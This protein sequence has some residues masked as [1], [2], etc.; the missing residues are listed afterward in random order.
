MR[1]FECIGA[2][3]RA[4][5]APL[6]A[7]DWPA[8]GRLMTLNQMVLEKIGVSSPALEALVEAALGAGAH[9]AKLAGS[10]GGGIM[11]ALTG[12]ERAA[13]VGAA[14]A[15]A[16]G[17]PLTPDLAV[18]GAALVAAGPPDRTPKEDRHDRHH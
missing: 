9:G 14:I 18:P 4:A 17:R 12:G 6:A 1:Y 5:L 13:A 16:G 7:G 2:L 8:L 15:A 10:G 3:S 11:I